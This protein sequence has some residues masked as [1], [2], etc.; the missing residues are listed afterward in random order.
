MSLTSYSGLST[1]IGTWGTRTYSQDQLDEFIL[2][3]EA[4]MNRR[5][6]PHYTRETSATVT[7]TA[8]AASIPTGFVRAISLVHTTYGALDQATIAT[9][10]ERRVWDTAGIPYIYAVTGTTIELAAVYTGDLTLDYE[11]RFTGLSGS[12]TSNWLLAL[13]PDAYLFYCRAAQAAYEEEFQQAGIF[14]AKGAAVID[15]VVLEAM[16][17]KLGNATVHLP[18]Y[19]P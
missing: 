15:E 3:A 18:G 2:L 1:A 12:N 9:V 8:G 10:R 13:A 16:V 14:E 11:A 4:S 6:G 17:G 5:L 19:T 7:F